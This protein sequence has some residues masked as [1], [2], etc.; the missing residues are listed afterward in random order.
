MEPVVI[1]VNGHDLPGASCIPAPDDPRP[2]D[3]VHVGIG[4]RE[5]ATELVRGDASEATWR[6][7]VR[8]IADE[9]R[10]FDFRGP[11]VDG[12][13]GDRF[14]YLNWVNVEK[15]G[16]CRLFRRAKI[17]LTDIDPALVERAVADET[18]LHCDAGL[19]D[20]KGN[21]NCPRFRRTELSW[22]AVQAAPAR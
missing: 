11:L 3:N 12:P 15:D 8:A 14:L 7:E 19:T 18:E 1:Q 6:F 13:R 21:P 4:R 5:M 9:N 22:K 17:M 20:A 16:R 2:H 10:R